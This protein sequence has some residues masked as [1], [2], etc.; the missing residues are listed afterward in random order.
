MPLRSITAEPQELQLLC[1]A[2][3]EAWSA[4]NAARPIDPL[5][6]AAEK[7]RLGYIITQLWQNGKMG[8]LADQSAACFLSGTAGVPLL[9]GVKR[10]SSIHKH[11]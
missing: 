5:Q 9:P 4:V 11:G 7:E 2:F 10:S 8:D 3:D 6:A 1:N